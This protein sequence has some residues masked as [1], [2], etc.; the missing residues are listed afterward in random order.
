MPISSGDGG[1]FPHLIKKIDDKPVTKY[2]YAKDFKIDP[3][4]FEIVKKGMRAA[5]SDYS[6]TAHTLEMKEVFVAG[7]T[8]T[9]QSVPNKAHHAW[10][11]GYAHGE[12]KNIAFTVFLEHGGSS[13]NATLLGR[14]L[15]QKMHK[16]NLL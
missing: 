8:G 10:F 12:L 5:V 6:G 2:D 15:L 16:N 11:V 3:K 1:L 7:K 13:H 14:E 9:A 4:I